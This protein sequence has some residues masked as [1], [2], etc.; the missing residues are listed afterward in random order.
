MIIRGNG[1]KILMTLVLM[2]ALL[3]TTLSG[4]VLGTPAQAQAAGRTRI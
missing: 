4:A 2:A 1:K 3:V